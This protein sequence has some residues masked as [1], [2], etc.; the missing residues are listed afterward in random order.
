[1]YKVLCDGTLMCDSR[2][3]ELA[4]I[5]PV[6]KLEENKAGSFSFI[7]PPNHPFCDSVQR[8]K[9][10]IEVYRDDEAEPVFSGICAE[11]DGDFNKQ[12][13]VTCEGDFTFLN[14]SI[15]RPFK[16]QGYTV[17]GL[18]EAFIENHNVQVE[19]AKHFKVGIVTVADSNNYITCYTNMESTMQCLKE[20]LVDDLGGIIRVRHK[21]GIRYIDYLKESPNTNSQVIKFGKNLLDFTANFSTNDIATAIIPLGA[22]LEE[23]AVEGLE[24]RLTI[25]SVNNGID[26][27]HSAEAVEEYGWIYKT[28][29]F[30]DVTTPEALKLKGEKYLAETQFESMVINAKAIDLHLTDKAIESF[31][32]SDQ[33]RVQSNPHGLNKYFRLTK[34]TLNL[35]NPEKDTVTLGKNE[36]IS[37][38]AK[39]IQISEEIKKAVESIVPP[40]VVLNQAIA[41]ATALITN[42][43]GGYVVKTNDELLIMDTDNI[44]TATK[45]WRWNI[46]GLGYSSTGYNGKYA[47]AMTMD[48]RFVADAIT[49]EGLEVGKNVKLGENATI[50][51]E[52]VENVPS[53]IADMQIGG[54]NLLKHSSDFSADWWGNNTNLGSAADPFGGNEAYS[55]QGTEDGNNYLVQSDVFKQSGKYVVSFWAK[56][57][58]ACELMVGSTS[59]RGGV[60]NLTTE[61]QKFEVRLEVAITNFE[62]LALG[63][64]GTWTSTDTIIYLYHPKVEEGT[65]ATAWSL[66]PAEMV[67][68][69]K[70]SA[71]ISSEDGDITIKA[72]RFSWEA[73]NSSLTKDGLLTAKSAAIKD[74]KLQFGEL[75]SNYFLIDTDG[76]VGTTIDSD[77][78]LP[79][80]RLKNDYTERMLDIESGSIYWYELGDDNV[81]RSLA[82]V[83]YLGQAKFQRTDVTSLTATGSLFCQG[84]KS[85]IATTENYND[86]LLYCYE[87]PTPYF[88][89]I[90]EGHLDDVGICYVY[91]D[92]I[93]M[94]TVD[95]SCN[96]Q[97]FLQKYGE[98]DLI[99]S[100]RNQGYFVV[101]GTPGLPFA[102]E[103]KAKQAGYTMERLE[104]FAQTTDGESLN[105][106]AEATV[107]LSNYEKEILNYA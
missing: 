88:G 10:I 6:V 40:N 62:W 8:R 96:Y 2:I 71:Q 97:V 106:E 9:T 101:S 1:M 83:N 31:K 19:E 29:E 93:F 61:W 63:S 74:G 38:S 90:G 78:T 99:V 35:N 92:N 64:Y 80:I 26:Y 100:E 45:V 86:R 16:Y 57:S 94:E 82:Y 41:N 67:E 85:R 54:A 46:N 13:K 33:I 49:V 103:I 42:A 55:F 14:D 53:D 50:S 43:M 51:W 37:L 77:Y 47:L 23:S 22:K 20:D 104:E 65:V 56:A 21:N 32:I 18:L 17:R 105:Y 72:N 98:G 28:I 25:S 89:D 30:D 34:Q 76:I 58:E 39:S 4:L 102:W 27:V 15:Q 11:A 7:I 81:Y 107:Y 68:K 60:C 79:A 12:K 59:I 24:T 84:T 95:M 91:I 66:S 5:N 3:E 75:D 36:K 70:V 48:G 44:E 52:Q 73:D 69:G 87:M